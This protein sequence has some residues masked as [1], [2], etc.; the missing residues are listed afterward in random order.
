MRK[1]AVLV[2]ASGSIIGEGIIKCLKL[3]NSVTDRTFTYEI[4][5]ADM[6][7]DAAGLYRGDRGEIL[8]A[9]Q[10]ESRYYDTLSSVCRKYS[11][12]GI[13]CGS[14]EELLPMA[15]LASRIENE[16]SAKVISNP[17]SVLEVSVDKWKTFEFL[18]KKGLDCPETCLAED[19]NELVEK[20]GFPLIVKP[21]TGHGSLGLYLVRNQEETELALKKIRKAHGDP[22][23]QEYLRGKDAEFTTGIAVSESTLKVLSSI[24]MRRRLKHGQTYKAFVEDIEPVRTAAENVALSLGCQGPLN[25]QSRL[26]GSQSKTFEVNPRFSASCPI[27]AVSGVNEPDIIFRDQVLKEKVA[28]QAK[29]KKLVALRYWNELFVPLE[30]YQKA[31]TSGVISGRESFIPEYF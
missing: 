26:V 6:R 13:F 11:I 24:V 27:R 16:T 25:V 15:R 23:V 17:P 9:P 10:D 28:Q 18:K 31:S 20:L 3:A 4:V 30:T 8:P 19:R 14:D 21:R 7:A 2:T 5:V 12:R 1:E 22:I 29:Y